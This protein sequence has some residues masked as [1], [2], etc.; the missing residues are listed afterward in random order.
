MKEKEAGL[1]SNGVRGVKKA[2]NANPL[3]LRDQTVKSL[4]TEQKNDFMKGTNVGLNVYS[5]TEQKY[6]I[7]QWRSSLHHIG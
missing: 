5:V 6:D 1:A 2:R 3:K 7:N 4:V